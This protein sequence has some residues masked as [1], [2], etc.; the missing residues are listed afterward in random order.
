MD[1]LDIPEFLR[2]PAEQRLASW[3]GKRC[4]ATTEMRLKID[5]RQEPADVK[6]FRLEQERK[7][8]AK[9]NERF[10]MLRQREAEKRKA[11]QR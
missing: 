4:K 8:K 5:K 6:A 9:N 7:R 1:D 2:I 10:K 3:K 11:V